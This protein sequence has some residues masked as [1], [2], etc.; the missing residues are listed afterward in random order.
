MV[1]KKAPAENVNVCTSRRCRFLGN[2][3][4]RN[5]I[6]RVHAWHK[7]RRHRHLKWFPAAVSS[8]ETNVQAAFGSQLGRR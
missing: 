5:Y 1:I 4:W 3:K 8:R 6:N 2:K 7:V